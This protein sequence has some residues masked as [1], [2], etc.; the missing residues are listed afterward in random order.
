MERKGLPSAGKA[1]V[2]RGSSATRDHFAENTPYRASPQKAPQRTAGVRIRGLMPPQPALSGTHRLRT[3]IGRRPPRSNRAPGQDLDPKLAAAYRCP[4]GPFRGLWTETM[5]QESGRS[6]PHLYP[7]SPGTY[8]RPTPD[9]VPIRDV[10]SRS[11]PLLVGMLSVSWM[12]VFSGDRDAPGRPIQ[13]ARASSVGEQQRAPHD[14]I[15]EK[16]RRGDAK[17]RRTDSG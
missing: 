12:C 15:L 8:P 9:V 6:R 7:P 14:R 11:R 13:I 10:E 1:A 17:P 2:L 3:V 16:S 4:A 5:E